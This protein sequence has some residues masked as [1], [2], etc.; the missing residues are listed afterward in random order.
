MIAILCSPSAR[1]VLRYQKGN[2]FVVLK[3]TFQQ[4]IKSE[5]K[6]KGIQ[7]RK[8]ESGRIERGRKSG[9]LYRGAL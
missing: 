7:H 3:P 4:P 5:W 9:L 2:L 8:S 6:K 1:R